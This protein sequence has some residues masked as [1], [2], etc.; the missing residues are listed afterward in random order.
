MILAGK[1]KWQERSEE[2][3]D[4]CVAK[5][6]SISKLSIK[7]SVILHTK[8][9][10]VTSNYVSKGNLP[11]I[12]AIFARMD[13]YYKLFILYHCIIVLIDNN[14]LIDSMNYAVFHY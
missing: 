14:T 9:I 13:I 12:L 10:Y 2:Q 7:A 6:L 8:Y 3:S 5:W 11:L 1:D 4:A